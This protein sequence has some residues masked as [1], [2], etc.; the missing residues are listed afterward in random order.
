[1]I[2]KVEIDGE[3]FRFLFDSGAPMVLTPATAAR[4]NFREAGITT[5]KDSQGNV[6][7]QPW[8]YISSVKLGNVAFCEL[9]AFVVDLSNAPAVS[10]LGFDGIVGANLLKYG[11]W[12]VDY[13]EGVIHFSNKSKNL[14]VALDSY[15]KMGLSRGQTS[16]Y[17]LLG[18]PEKARTFVLFDTGYNGFLDLHTKMA[19]KQVSQEEAPNVAYGIGTASEGVFGKGDY[20]ENKLLLDYTVIAGDTI[21]QI[22]AEISDAAT[23]KVGV[24][25]FKGRNVVLDFRKKRFWITQKDQAYEPHTFETFGFGF[26]LTK[27]TTVQVRKLWKSTPATELGLE[28]GDQ[29]L[30]VNDIDLE[31]LKEVDDY[32]S[33]FFG[34][35]DRVKNQD[36]IVVLVRREEEVLEFTVKKVRLL[37]VANQ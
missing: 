12:W 30:K 16:P 27:D 5:V 29:L 9:T 36:E 22:V 11:A 8:G 15:S 13:E 2:V 31:N 25:F 20:D 23:T 3:Q 33:L 24:E 1:M 7:S 26:S 28:I 34:L 6:V 35:T 10:C 21:E 18:T 37:G 14:P 4:I 17:M 32:C 19:R